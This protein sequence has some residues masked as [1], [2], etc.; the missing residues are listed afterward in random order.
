MGM[1]LTL[2]QLEVGSRV[3]LAT[4]PEKAE[5]TVTVI[6][7]GRVFVTWD[8]MGRTWVYAASALRLV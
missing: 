3:Y 5:G 2:D 1:M 6:Q 4:D 8:R 7:A